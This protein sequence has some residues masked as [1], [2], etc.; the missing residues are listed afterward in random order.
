MI[1]SLAQTDGSLIDLQGQVNQIEKLIQQFEAKVENLASE[2]QHAHSALIE[3]LRAKLEGYR[4]GMHEAVSAI[5]D[6]LITGKGEKMKNREIW[7][8]LIGDNFFA[9]E[10]MDLDNPSEGM[11]QAPTQNGEFS[12]TKQVDE[13]KASEP[14]VN[15][16]ELLNNENNNV[17]MNIQPNIV[18]AALAAAVN[19]DEGFSYTTMVM[20][21]TALNELVNIEKVKTPVNAASFRNLRNFIRQFII[22]CKEMHIN[23]SFLEPV[24][25]THIIA[26]FDDATFANWKYFMLTHRASTKTMREFLATQEE[27]A[28]DK[29]MSQGREILARAV[30]AAQKVAKGTNGNLSEMKKGEIRERSVNEEGAGC[31]HW[32][33][34]EMPQRKAQSL[35]TT[36]KVKYSAPSSESGSVK[37]N[38]IGKRAKE[39]KPK[40]KCMG[41][42]GPHPLFF[43]EK[44]LS[45]PLS[46]RLEFV[47]KRKIC[48]LCLIAS[49][50]IMECPDRVCGQCKQ[51]HNSTL[52]EK[53]IERKKLPPKENHRKGG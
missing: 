7:D 31:S 11:S 39:K 18:N 50:D 1:E 45:L 17:N 20:Y 4:W 37:E 29:W 46:K 13:E 30:M 47:E 16:H 15:P 12:E 35:Q 34:S 49:H 41:C 10:S 44:Y 38:A 32:A 52:C 51:P 36:P 40:M 28:G 19:N 23:F 25:L 42:D 3:E 27:M 21:S 43:C 5:E 53:S 6:H 22:L 2:D 14:Q 9:D 26:S 8:E 24:L 48:P 33:S